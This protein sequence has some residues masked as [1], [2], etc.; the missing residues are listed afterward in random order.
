MPITPGKY[1]HYSGKEYEVIEIALLADNGQDNLKEM[2]V[3]R[4][5]G[6]Y[7]E[8]PKGSIW[9]RRVNEFGAEVEIRGKLMKRF[10]R[11]GD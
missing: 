10:E 3:Y 6:D 1:R 7:G 9:V 8:Y 11:V 4:Q 2:V 5:L